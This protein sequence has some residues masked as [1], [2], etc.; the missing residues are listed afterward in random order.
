MSS[1][2]YIIYVCIKNKGLG[3]G[4]QKMS[5]PSPHSLRASRLKIETDACD[6]E[7]SL[8]QSSDTDNDS[9]NVRSRRLDQLLADEGESHLPFSVRVGVSSDVAS[10]NTLGV[11]SGDSIGGRIDANDIINHNIDDHIHDDQGGKGE[12]S[13]S[14]L[15]ASQ[16]VSSELTL[17]RKELDRGR[18]AV[19][20]YAVRS[21]VGRPSVGLGSNSIALTPQTQ[22]HPGTAAPPSVSTTPILNPEP[23][24]PR[25]LGP[26]TPPYRPYTA[27]RDHLTSP[28]LAVESAMYTAPTSLRMIG[29]N[30]EAVDGEIYDLPPAGPGLPVGR[31]PRI[32]R[33]MQVEK[34]R[35]VMRGRGYKENRNS[36]NTGGVGD[37]SNESDE[38]GS[39]ECGSEDLSSEDESDLAESRV[40]TRRKHRD[41]RP[42]KPHA[43]SGISE[44][45]PQRHPELDTDRILNAMRD[46]I[47]GLRSQLQKSNSSLQENERTVERLQRE[48]DHQIDKITGLRTKLQSANDRIG[49]LKATLTKNHAA[50]SIVAELE[51]T[52]ERLERRVESREAEITSLIRENDN[53]KKSAVSLESAAMHAHELAK[54]A[55]ENLRFMESRARNAEEEM[56]SMATQYNLDLAGVSQKVQQVER[57]NVYLKTKVLKK[58][59]L[60]Q[61][62]KGILV[63]LQGDRERLAQQ[64]DKLSEMAM[65]DSVD[66]S[67]FYGVAGA[68]NSGTGETLMMPAEDRDAA[69]PDNEDGDG[70]RVRGSDLKS[71]HDDTS[72]R[73]EGEEASGRRMI[74]KDLL[75]STVKQQKMKEERSQPPKLTGAFMM[76]QGARLNQ[77]EPQHQRPNQT[78][79]QFFAKQ[80]KILKTLLRTIVLGEGEEHPLYRRA[81]SATS[82]EAIN[83]LIRRTVSNQAKVVKKKVKRNPTRKRGLNAIKGEYK[84][85]PVNM[86]FKKALDRKQ[87]DTLWRILLSDDEEAANIVPLL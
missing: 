7:A 82:E 17:L 22:Q 11:A 63:D 13:N 9:V 64:L 41:E 87:A 27:S 33:D 62:Q 2:I 8:I 26:P 30:V 5:P 44:R 72:E 21:S 83:R 68:A 46:E 65:V 85:K 24:S 10:N 25:D 12:A 15:E 36:W 53:L 38:G 76:Q 49:Q 32:G 70:E 81:R 14:L 34:A 35:R 73:N 59:E 42:R 18:G 79:T 58:K 71:E 16:Q 61:K 67:A 80:N 78:D 37:E 39:G 74:K 43:Q 45:D 69:A 47:L 60:L 55:E 66:S 29:A 20:D 6:D 56:R 50:T 77:D 4:R 1:T 28:V 48:K 23:S 75:R 51:H 84:P 19:S 57:D 54:V 52:T 31:A 3:L 86:N 40:V